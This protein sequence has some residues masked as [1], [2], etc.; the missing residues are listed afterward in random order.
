MWIS[1]ETSS[2]HSSVAVGEGES[3]MREIALDGNASLI[4][5]PLIRDLKLDFNSLH[6]C[7]IGQGPGSYNGLRVGYAFLKGL[8][9]LHPLPVAQVP[10]PLTLA[11]QGQAT[12][13][14]VA[15]ASFLI[16]NNARRGEIYSALVEVTDEKP[17][18]RWETIGS[19]SALLQR[20][21]SRLAAIISSDYTSSD[22]PA[23]SSH[24]WLSLAPSAATAGQLAHRLKLPTSNNLSK[25]EP[26][27][28]RAPVP[29]KPIFPQTRSPLEN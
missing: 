11:M 12:M 15:P 1:I 17:V 14:P 24:Q 16:L 21:P 9:C 6:Y 22:L 3:C 23:F 8:L 27:Y 20:L 5:E 13:K 25:L 19:E 28:V 26:H 10:T 29:E 2:R 7:V 18:L 4:L